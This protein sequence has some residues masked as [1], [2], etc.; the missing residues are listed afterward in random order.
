MASPSR[1]SL[2]SVGSDPNV[3]VV[4]IIKYHQITADSSQQLQTPNSPIARAKPPCWLKRAMFVSTYWHP[5][6]RFNEI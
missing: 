4:D 5:T 3:R 2:L 1:K 6:H